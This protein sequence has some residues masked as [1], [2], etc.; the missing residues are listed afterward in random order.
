MYKI[1]VTDPSQR[2]TEG[3]K[4]LNILIVDDDQ[5]SRESLRDIIKARGHNVTTL[6]EGMKCVNRCSKNTYDIIF[7]DYHMD[8][9]GDGLGEI[10]G[11]TVAKLIQE[12]FDTEYN[13]YA[14]TGDNST[15]AINQFKQNKMK[16]VFVK[17]VEPTL[18]IEFFRIVEKD[19]NDQIQ[20]S[21]LAIKRK[22]FMYFKPTTRIHNILHKK[23]N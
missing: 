2:Y 10:N 20:L 19:I 1:D 18:I 11:T 13:V 6:D 23:C 9:L 15:D 21:R 16:G 8:D 4:R 7:M 14:Y 12:C 17:P 5:A 22:N 3:V